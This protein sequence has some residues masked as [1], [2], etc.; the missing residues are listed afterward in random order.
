MITERKRRKYASICKLHGSDM[1]DDLRMRIDYVVRTG[2]LDM[3]VEGDG[4]D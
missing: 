1:S 3:N 2:K 4:S